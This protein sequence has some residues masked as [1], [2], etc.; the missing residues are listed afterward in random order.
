MLKTG[1]LEVLITPFRELPMRKDLAWDS[2][3]P[4]ILSRNTEAGYG[5]IP[6]LEKEANSRLHCLIIKASKNMQNERQ[7][8][9]ID[10]DPD[11]CWMLS[12]I[13]KNKNFEVRTTSLIIDAKNVLKNF[14]P[15]LIILDNKLPD[16]RGK[17]FITFLT[18]TLPGA[19]IIFI[20]AHEEVL[21]EMEHSGIA[22]SLVKPFSIGKFRSAIEKLETT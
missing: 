20:S 22:T 19:K 10:D 18:G 2:S 1:C 4:G 11:I 9:I 5:W 6:N 8:L 16:G 12:E 14:N 13:L 21:E 3:L 7:A 15:L 17:D